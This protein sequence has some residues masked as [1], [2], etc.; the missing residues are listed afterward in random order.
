[1]IFK[2]LECFNEFMSSIMLWNNYKANI[3]MNNSFTLWISLW[4]DYFYKSHSLCSN[5][6][7]YYL[8]DFNLKFHYKF[9]TYFTNWFQWFSVCFLLV[10]L[11]INFYEFC[12][13]IFNIILIKFRVFIRL[14]NLS[15]SVWC[16]NFTLVSK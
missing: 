15:R 12:Q 10:F 2:S 5:D 8:L 14:I 1:M 9:F 16:N 6:L 7:L 13:I 4:K 11:L 3:I